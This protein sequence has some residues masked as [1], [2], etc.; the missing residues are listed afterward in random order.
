VREGALRPRGVEP[1][2]VGDRVLVLYDGVCGLCDRLVQF[3][4][5][6]DAHDA[7]RFVALQSDVGRELLERHGCDPTLLD[8]FYVVRD[9]G[10]NT[11]RLLARSDA[12][13]ACAWRL[14]F[15]WRLFAAVGSLAPRVLRDSIYNFVA[16]RRYRWFGRLE[17]CRIPAPKERTKF[18]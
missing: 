3:L 10:S 18:I 7:F 11:E 15:G 2:L 17:A 14:H 5:K 12:A 6:R 1:A 16:T 9:L 13:L 4:L 8:T